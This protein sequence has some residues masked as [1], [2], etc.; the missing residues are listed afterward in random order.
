MYY[1]NCIFLFRNV[2]THQT[3][4]FTNV[5]LK[6]IEIP[7]QHISVMCDLQGSDLHI[8]PVLMSYNCSHSHLGRLFYRNLSH[9]SDDDDANGDDNDDVQTSI[10]TD[11]LFPIA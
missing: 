5:T 9:S 1:V 11:W 3:D 6:L 7:D 2:Q 8:F 4:Y 10:D